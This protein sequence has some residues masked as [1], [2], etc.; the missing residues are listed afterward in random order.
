MERDHPSHSKKQELAD[1]RGSE[2]ELALTHLAEILLLAAGRKAGHS[3]AGDTLIGPAQTPES[4]LRQIIPPGKPAK[5]SP[6]RPKLT[7]EPPR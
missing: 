4:L 5:A 3:V 2:G 6:H 1:T 7:A